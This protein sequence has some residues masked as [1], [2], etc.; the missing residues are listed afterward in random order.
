MAICNTP[1]KILVVGGNPVE[2]KKANETT[3]LTSETRKHVWC[4]V[5]WSSGS[6]GAVVALP[7]LS[8]LS[9]QCWNLS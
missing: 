8:C 1:G 2:N 9:V 3:H 5:V 7:V 4:R 6:I